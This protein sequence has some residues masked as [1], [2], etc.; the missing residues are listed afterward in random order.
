MEEIEKL[1]SRGLDEYLENEKYAQ[2]EDLITACAVNLANSLAGI[3]LEMYKVR[4]IKMKPDE[5]QI[6]SDIQIVIEHIAI[7]AHCLDLE[8]PEY[9][10]IMEFY[11][12]E[13]GF[14]LKMDVCLAAMNA[15]YIS[16]NMSLEY[17]ANGFGE[18]DPIDNS[19]MQVGILDVICSMMAIC[20]R[21]GFD[22]IDVVVRG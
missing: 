10:E 5:N 19:M 1:K 2:V 20:E 6:R 15:N 18:D 11:E 9:E 17:F 4:G 16:S 3:M 8:I 12:D 7:L 14:D 22:F 13:T 21:L